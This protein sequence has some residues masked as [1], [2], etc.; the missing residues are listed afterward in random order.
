V[1]RLSGYQDSAT[2]CSL[3]S[4]PRTPTV[5]D[6]HVRGDALR[7]ERMAISYRVMVY[8]SAV[9]TPSF[10][11]MRPPTSREAL[12][13]PRPPRLVAGAG[14]TAA[15]HRTGGALLAPGLTHAGCYDLLFAGSEHVRP[16]GELRSSR[17]RELHLDAPPGAAL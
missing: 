13:A 17:I 15:R 6:G 14:R 12:A 5:S 11:E 8:R 3:R 7:T 1:G 4:P 10:M 9:G 16:A 2:T